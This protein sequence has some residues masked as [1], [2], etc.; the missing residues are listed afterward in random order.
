MSSRTADSGKCVFGNRHDDVGVSVLTSELFGSFYSD[1]VNV[2]IGGRK[3]K[4]WD[5]C[6]Y[7][8][9]TYLSRDKGKQKRP[10]KRHG[11]SLLELLVAIAVLFVL[12]GIMLPSLHQAVRGSARL[13]QC[14]NNLYQLR[15]AFMEYLGENEGLLPNANYHPL[16]KH[17]GMAPL[18]E[19]LYGESE[20]PYELWICPADPDRVK[21]LN[22]HRSSYVY[23]PSK[24]INDDQASSAV[25]DRNYSRILLLADYKAFHKQRFQPESQ[26]YVP[27]RSGK[28]TSIWKYEFNYPMGHNRLRGDG[29]IT[30]DGPVEEQNARIRR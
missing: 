27:K 28:G 21:R 2:C 22:G 20:P 11:F 15:Q 7:S 17:G 10:C 12:I 5:L 18:S 6:V 24:L 9:H 4:K 23:P 3:M 14:S 29:Q 19:S 1:R 13:I 16:T 8:S 30:I 25:T 26:I